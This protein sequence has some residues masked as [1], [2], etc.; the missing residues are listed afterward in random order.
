MVHVVKKEYVGLGRINWSRLKL[1]L[2]TILKS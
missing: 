1:I 2:S